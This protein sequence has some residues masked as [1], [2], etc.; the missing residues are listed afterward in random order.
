MAKPK[1][2]R[3]ILN[4]K[5]EV[6]GVEVLLKDEWVKAEVGESDC[7]TVEDKDDDAVIRVGA[8]AEPNSCTNDPRCKIRSSLCSVYAG[9]RCYYY[10]C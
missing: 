7:C 1:K 10:P 8:I 3:I 9:G 5:N 6:E 4:D 2:V